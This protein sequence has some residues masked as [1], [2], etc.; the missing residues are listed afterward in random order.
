[1]F[2]CLQAKAQN[3]PHIINISSKGYAAANKNWSVDQD[4]NGVLYFGNDIGLLEYDGIEWQLHKVPNAPIVRSVCVLSDQTLFTG[5]YEDFGRWDRDVSGKLVYTS[6][7]NTLKNVTIKNED[8]WK[9]V[10]HEG[11]VYFQSFDN[12]YVYDMESV[13]RIDSD[14]GVLF[15]C[16]VNDQLWVQKMKGQMYRI[17]GNKYEPV[18]GSELF[19]DTDAR[20]IIPFSDNKILVGT[21]A[22]GL[23]LYDGERFSEWNGALSKLL[24]TRELNCGI[25]SSKGTFYLGTILDGI[26]EVDAG[27]RVVN[28]ISADNTLQNNTVLSIFEDNASNVWACLDRGISYIKRQDD[29]MSYYID[30]YGKIGTMYGAVV[31]NGRLFMGTNQGVFSVAFGDLGKPDIYS[32]IKLVEGTQGQVWNLAVIDDRLYCCHNSGLKE[33]KPDLRVVAF[34]QLNSGA[35]NILKTRLHDKDLLL[36]STYNSLYVLYEGRIIEPKLLRESIRDTQIDHLNNIWLEH[37]NKG[38]Y[39]C[40]I[41]H[42]LNQLTSVVPFGG[43]DD[44]LPYKLSLFKVGGKMMFVGDGM[45]YTYDEIT[46]HIVPCDPLNDCF[47]SINDIKKIVPVGNN[48]FWAITATS[49]YKFEYDG[50]TPLITECYDMANNNLSLVNAYESIS[51]LN[52]DYNLICL[53][54]GF[55]LYD[56]RKTGQ[57]NYCTKQL[58]SPHFTSVS[59]ANAKGNSSYVDTSRP[60]KIGYKN[61]S[62]TIWFTAKNI[63]ADNIHFSYMLSEVDKEWSNALK[64]NNASYARLPKGEYEFMVQAMD[65]HGNSSETASYTFTIRPP[66]YGSYLAYIAYVLLGLGILGLTWV[67]ILKRYRTIHLRKVRA[68]EVE[69]LWRINELLHSKVEAKNAEMLSLASYITQKNAAIHKIKDEV[70]MFSQKNSNKALLPLY[71]KINKLLN[72]SLDM[73]ADWKTFLIRFEEKHTGFF[74]KLRTD[75][76]Q[77]TPS[78][79][80][81][82]ACLRLNLDSKDIAALMNISVRA[83]ENNRYRIRKKLNIP[84]HQ[85]LYDFFLSI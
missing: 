83:V 1:M 8:F 11:N 47:A 22:D 6:L 4:G 49:L 81:L 56:A 19:E 51:V 61:N 78:D 20:V 58:E 5:G 13:S 16:G 50:Y 7:C 71:I 57:N 23:F 31:W 45:F 33:I 46:D 60:S 79:L 40:K 10:I 38:V 76:P 68:R 30:P 37:H 44:E 63:L 67:L 2:C 85:N 27:G 17:A 35:F 12:I 69:R 74:Q 14:N 70:E 59:V 21:A 73:E 72:Q 41:S 84:S 48:R 82:S 64:T 42:D 65:S 36:L 77:L 54:D 55:M 29:M 3:K 39:R 28:H 52:D 18:A 25:R 43:G 9:I 26:Y 24:S 62:I 53:D 34:D 75:Y 32:G 15:L 66:W 80:R